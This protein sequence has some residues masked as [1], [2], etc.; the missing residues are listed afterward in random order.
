V[1]GEG[2]GWRAFLEEV[3]SHET[4][5]HNW[6][7][8]PF[9]RGE[10]EFKKTMVEFKEGKIH[11]TVEDRGIDYRRREASILEKIIYK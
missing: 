4:E 2:E 3:K 6:R 1:D 8:C 9:F 10:D 7:V 11:R 5:I